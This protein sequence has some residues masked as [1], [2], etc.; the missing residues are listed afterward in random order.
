[1]DGAGTWVHDYVASYRYKYP[2]AML[3]CPIFG[4]FPILLLWRSGVGLSVAVGAEVLLFV[5][6]VRWKTYCVQLEPES[7]SAASVF[8]RKRFALSDVDLIQHLC[9]NRGDHLLRIRHSDRIFLTVTQD[10]DGFDDLVG[11]F[12]E[13]AKHHGLIFATRNDWGEWTQAGGNVARQSADNG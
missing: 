3:M 12:R 9:G 6:F 7:V 8:R 10:L 13:Y 1:M 11:F 5:A 4:L 2:W